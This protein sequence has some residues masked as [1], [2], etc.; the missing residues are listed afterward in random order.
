MF[1]L[2]HAVFNPRFFLTKYFSLLNSVKFVFAVLKKEISYSSPQSHYRCRMKSFEGSSNSDE[3]RR[4][5]VPDDNIYID[6]SC[7]SLNDKEPNCC[8]NRDANGQM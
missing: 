6:Y 4:R 1:L 3:D 5:S 7:S 2:Q 8:C